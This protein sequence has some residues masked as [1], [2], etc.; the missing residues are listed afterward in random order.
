[1]DA[2][3]RHSYLSRKAVDGISQSTRHQSTSIL[4]HIKVT[5][6]SFQ[7]VTLFALIAASMAFA[8]NQVPQGELF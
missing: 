3:Q 6:K 4:I 8:P 1:M 7:I 2:R 5:M